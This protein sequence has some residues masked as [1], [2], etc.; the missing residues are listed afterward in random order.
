MEEPDFDTFYANLWQQVAPSAT[1]SQFSRDLDATPT[2][3]VISAFYL[4][5]LHNKT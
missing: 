4:D 5:P 3:C 2:T 1:H